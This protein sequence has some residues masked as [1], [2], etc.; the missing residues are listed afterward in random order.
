MGCPLGVSKEPRLFPYGDK[1]NINHSGNYVEQL[2]SYTVP[3]Y[4]G[5]LQ[6]VPKK[7]ND[8]GYEYCNV[9]SASA[10]RC[11]RLSSAECYLSQ[12]SIYESA[13]YVFVINKTIFLVSQ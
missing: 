13:N 11:Q 9:Q 6:A 10:Q 7:C 2:S 3:C 5:Q 12:M 8:L 1:A 4:F